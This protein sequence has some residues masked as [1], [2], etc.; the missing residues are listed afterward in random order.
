[1]VIILDTFRKKKVIKQ[2]T[3]K[4]KFYLC[5]T[6]N[7]IAMGI[8]IPFIIFVCSISPDKSCSVEVVVNSMRGLAL[9]DVIVVCACLQLR[10]YWYK[11]ILKI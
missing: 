7:N 8:Y 5:E 4:E 6:V 3:T 10:L 1:M 2:R 9:V 11:K